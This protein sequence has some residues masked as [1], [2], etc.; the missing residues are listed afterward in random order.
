MRAFT[1]TLAIKQRSQLLSKVHIRSYCGERAWEG[2]RE[3]EGGGE[4][5]GRERN[6]E[7]LRGK[8]KEPASG[9]N[10]EKTIPKTKGRE[11]LS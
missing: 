4:T 8:K 7:T 11:T 6:R 1:V 10:K 2:G 9:G 3:G 5:R